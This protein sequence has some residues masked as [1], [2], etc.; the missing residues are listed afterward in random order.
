MLFFF[1]KFWHFV[2]RFEWVRGD[3]SGK[4]EENKVER[5][6]ILFLGILESRIT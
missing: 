6:F 3:F 4:V 2:A 5:E 1:S